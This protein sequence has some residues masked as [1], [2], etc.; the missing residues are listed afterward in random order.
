MDSKFKSSFIPKSSFEEKIEEHPKYGLFSW[1][2]LIAFILSLISTGSFFFYKIMLQKEADNLKS[3]LDSALSSIDK[4]SI[5][6]IVLFD[7]RLE[8][9]KEV[10]SKHVAV[11]NYFK[12]LEEATVSQV[13]FV[14]LKYGAL[15]GSNVLVEMGGK[16]KSYAAIALQEDAFLKNQNTV[17]AS[18]G[19]MQIGDKD[20]SVSFAFKG[21]FKKDLIKFKLS[22]SAVSASSNSSNATDN[23]G[24]DILRD[25]DNLPDLENI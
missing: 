2:A 9:V 25:L 10:L 16:A 14:N 19:S 5:N 15:P 17:T 1:L 13:Q 7:K 3:Q 11:T 8:S 23:S 18:F 4:E 22:N 21:E 20:G 24:E 12:M 6:E